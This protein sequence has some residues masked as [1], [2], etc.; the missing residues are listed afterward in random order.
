MPKKIKIL[1]LS[2]LVVSL[3]L[4]VFR[5]DYPNTFIFDEVYY[6]FT[7][8]EY[9]DGNNQA[10]Q[11]W[12][13]APKDRGYGWVNPPLPQE[14]MA[15][16]MFIL[17]SRE[18]W[19]YR[20]PGVLFGILSI[21]L[22]FYIGKLLFKNEEI[23]LLAAFI[24]SLD[25]L[26]FTLSRIGML[27][28]YL[29]TFILLS[30]L[31][32]LQKKYWLSA[33]F[34]GLALASK[35]TAVLILPLYFILLLK[36]YR[37]LNL[38]YYLI[39]LPLV[40]LVCYIPFFLVGHNFYDFL[41]LLN[42]EVLYQTNLKATHDYASKWWSWPLNL[43]PVWIFAEY[44]TNTVA[45]IFASGHPLIFWGG[46]ASFIFVIWDFIKKREENLLF[47]ILGFFFLLVPWVFSPRI[48]F[49]YYFAPAVPFLSLALAYQINKFKERK[50][51][52]WGILTILSLTFLLL[53]PYLTAI[54]VPIWYPKF[55]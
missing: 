14:I 10:W 50:I 44:K 32:F 37:L 53:F 21:Y 2:L 42:Q 29:V 34:L 47:I 5:I 15:G 25:G 3:S 31:F 16:S 6:P 26:N 11:W 7:A 38:L 43:R 9:L 46:M 40:Y 30:V 51:V 13:K 55:F 41:N 45:N 23:S 22:V 17:G 1:L 35:W 8:G 20:L 39:F 36:N 19:A 12:T 52:F 33:I 49:H 18:S 28:I 27:D 24:F 48:T 4:R 54:P